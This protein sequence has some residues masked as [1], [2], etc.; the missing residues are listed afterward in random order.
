MVRDFDADGRPDTAVFLRD[1]TTVGPTVYTRLL[2]RLARGRALSW[3]GDWGLAPAKVRQALGGDDSSLVTVRSDP[4]GSEIVQYGAEYSCCPPALRVSRI[5]GAG[6]RTQVEFPE[7]EVL[8][9]GGDTAGVGF[10]TGAPCLQEMTG[11]AASYQPRIVIRLVAPFGIDSAASE[12]RTRH[13]AGGYAGLGCRA[14]VEVIKR[15]GRT[16][17]RQRAG[18]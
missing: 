3:T 14:D 2:V 11:E 16:E 18:P 13:V 15:N 10:L 17:L 5:D 6:L 9:L 12:A 4:S 1:T 7:F 8:E